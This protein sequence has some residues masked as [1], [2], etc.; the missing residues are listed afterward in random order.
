[1]DCPRPLGDGRDYA[2]F[3]EIASAFGRIHPGRRPGRTSGLRRQ[4][5]VRPAAGCGTPDRGGRF[6]PNSTEGTPGNYDQPDSTAGHTA[7]EDR[8]KPVAGWKRIRPGRFPGEY[9]Q[10]FSPLFKTTEGRSDR[11]Q[12]QQALPSSGNGLLR[13]SGR[14][15]PGRIP[16]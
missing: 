14:L 12:R 9:D 16:F 5:S 2:F 10:A 1:M 6:S 4:E 11:Q 7:A 15:S 3:L 8:R 13:S